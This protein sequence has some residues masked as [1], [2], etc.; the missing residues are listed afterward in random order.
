MSER[1]YVNFQGQDPI[2]VSSMDAAWSEVKANP[3]LELESIEH[4]HNDM[5]DDLALS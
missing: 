4:W 5:V 3:D 1:I 2:E